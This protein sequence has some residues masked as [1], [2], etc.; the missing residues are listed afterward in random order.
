MSGKGY[1]KIKNDR[2]LQEI[3]IGRKEFECI[4]AS[5]PLD[6]PHVYLNMGA[7]SSVLCPYC[8]TRFRFDPLLAADADPPDSLFEGLAGLG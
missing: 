6:H 3:R 1:S 2:G 7:A 4:G 5:P 8:G